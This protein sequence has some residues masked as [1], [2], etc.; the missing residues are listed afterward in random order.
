MR[1]HHDHSR[2]KAR[3]EVFQFRKNRHA[4]E[5]RHGQIEDHQIRLVLFDRGQRIDAIGDLKHFAPEIFKTAL[6]KRPNIGFIIDDEHL[7]FRHGILLGF[8]CPR[9]RRRPRNAR[10]RT[11]MAA[12]VRAKEVPVAPPRQMPFF[13]AIG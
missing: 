10:A 3:P 1:G 6:N 5:Q 8:Q 2:G 11:T 13:N 4:I 12:T 7:G 9:V